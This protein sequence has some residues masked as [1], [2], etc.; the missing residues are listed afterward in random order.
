MNISLLLAFA[1]LTEL[2]YFHEL[3]QVIHDRKSL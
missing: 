2:D 3:L 1:Q